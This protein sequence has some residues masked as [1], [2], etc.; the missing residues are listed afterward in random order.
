MLL[1]IF[2]ILEFTWYLAWWKV[3]FQS[4]PP[5]DKKRRSIMQ[6][7]ASVRLTP[8]HI[9]AIARLIELFGGSAASVDYSKAA[10][11]E[12]DIQTTVGLVSHSSSDS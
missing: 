3:H 1:D 9:S 12:L 5:N 4:I 8:R 6:Q 10:P 7:A 11:R 2:G